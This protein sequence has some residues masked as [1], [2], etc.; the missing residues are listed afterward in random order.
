[1]IVCGLNRGRD[2]Q[3]QTFEPSCDGWAVRVAAAGGPLEKTDLPPT[4]CYL[5]GVKNRDLKKKAQN[6]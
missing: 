3:H 1:M 5:R 2:R 6:G 4:V